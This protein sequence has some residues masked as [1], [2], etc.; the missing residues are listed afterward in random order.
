V[1]LTSP[2]VSAEAVPRS[3]LLVFL[4]WLLRITISLVLLG[5]VIRTYAKALKAHRRRRGRLPA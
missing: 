1:L 5:L 3:R 2:L 4:V